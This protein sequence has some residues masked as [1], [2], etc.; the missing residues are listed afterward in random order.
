MNAADHD[1]VNAVITEGWSLLRAGRDRESA[2]LFGRLL[3][4]DPGLEEARRGLAQARAA[5]DE[6][7][8]RLDAGLAEAQEAAD[9]GRRHAARALLEEVVRKGGDRDRALAALDRLDPRGGRALH[10]LAASPP[11][12][13]PAAGPA[14]APAPGAWARRGLAAACAAGFALLAAGVDARW[15]NLLGAL[16]R[17]PRPASPAAPPPLPLHAP[18]PGEQ[19]VADAR[20]LMEQGDAAGALAAL[21]RVTPEEPAYPFARQLRRQAESALLDGGAH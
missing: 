16:E 10:F 18:S 15:D 4:Q 9:R 11:A 14:L 19:A 7:M 2:D 8:R 20:R 13:G 6:T 5:A 1:R 17:A 21:D 3:L 12:E